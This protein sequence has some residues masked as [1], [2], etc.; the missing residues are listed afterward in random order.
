MDNE[1]PIEEE[2][3]EDKLTEEELEEISDDDDN[4]VSLDDLL[5]DETEE[6]LTLSFEQTIRTLDVSDSTKSRALSFFSGYLSDR[7]QKVTLTPTVSGDDISI[8]CCDDKVELCFVV[9][10]S[11]ARS[12]TG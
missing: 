8:I 5:E 9:S 3:V 1:K 10:E 12:I 2:V 4:K 7:L 11:L 6:E